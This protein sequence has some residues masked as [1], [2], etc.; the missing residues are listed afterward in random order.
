MHVDY[1][2]YDEM[3]TGLDVVDFKGQAEHSK[4]PE[5]GM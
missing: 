1:Q 2:E 5:S 3:L 4:R